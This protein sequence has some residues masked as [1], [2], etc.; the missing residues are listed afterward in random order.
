[1][2]SGFINE[3]EEEKVIS[4]ISYLVIEPSVEKKHFKTND[5]SKQSIFYL[6]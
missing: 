4:R 2:G 1:M 3:V 6:F 5:Y